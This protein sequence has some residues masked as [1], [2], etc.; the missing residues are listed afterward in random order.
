MSDKAFDAAN[1]MYFL[2]GFGA[3]RQK[4]VHVIDTGTGKQIASFVQAGTGTF[5]SMTVHPRCECC[6]ATN[7][8][9]QQ[10]PPNRRALPQVGAAG[11]ARCGATSSAAAVHFY[12]AE[13]VI[14]VLLV[15]A[16]ALDL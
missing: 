15:G 12:M 2:A 7:A 5:G 16:F 9:V 10:Q 11:F 1:Q 4:Q 3:A 14:L 6:L 8:D 13:A